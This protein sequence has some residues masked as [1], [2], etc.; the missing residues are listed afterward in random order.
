MLNLLRN[1]YLS[2]LLALLALNTA[3][4]SLSAWDCCEQPSCNRFYIGGF[5]GGLYSS[6][7]KMIQTGTAFFTED[8]GGPLAVNAPGHAR[9]NSSGFGGA[10]IGYEWLQC[11]INI[12]CTDWS[13]TPGAEVEAYFYKQTKHATLINES[14]RLPEH[15][16]V[17]SLPTNVGVYL[18]NGIFTLRNCCL[19]NF[20]PYVGGGIGVANLFV[21]KATSAQI[22]PP[23]AGV[24]HFNSDRSDRDWAFAAQ[25]KAGLRYNICER[26]HIFAEY[27]F[28]YLDSTR[29]TFGS[30]AYPGHA[31][32][33][34]WTI[35]MKSIYYNAFAI[36]IQFDI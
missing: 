19:G 15:D 21:R 13:I 25:A 4:S 1:H 16:F 5:G 36:G 12:G 3:D 11:P 26:F 17:N 10:Q 20:S 9:K 35:D 33:S 23:E 31:P 8:E 18:A 32:T 24:N 14:D 28:L 29:Y 6:S 27:R 7:P 22:S 30:T 2:A 34:P